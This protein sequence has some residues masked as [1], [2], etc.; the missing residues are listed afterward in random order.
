MLI[1]T[2]TE[3]GYCPS[4]GCNG[5]NEQII[6]TGEPGNCELK[7]YLSRMDARQARQLIA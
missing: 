5:P 2:F 6:A 3:G 1:L 4:A 7:Y